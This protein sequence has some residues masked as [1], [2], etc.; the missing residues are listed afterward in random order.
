MVGSATWFDAQTS[1][2]QELAGIR[3]NLKALIGRELFTGSAELMLPP[4]SHTI[5]TSERKKFHA[6][7]RRG[8]YRVKACMCKSLFQSAFASRSF[9]LDSLHLQVLAALSN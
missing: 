3:N 5:Q 8:W 9:P 4:P 1:I 7:Y 6:F 2:K